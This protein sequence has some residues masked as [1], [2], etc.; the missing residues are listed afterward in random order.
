MLGQC[1]LSSSCSTGVMPCEASVDT[2]NS[3]RRTR[4]DFGPTTHKFGCR[5]TRPIRRAG[6]RRVGIST[7]RRTLRNS[8]ESPQRPSPEVTCPHEAPLNPVVEQSLCLLEIR[9]IETLSEPGINRLKQIHVVRAPK[10][11]A[12]PL[13]PAATKPRIWLSSGSCSRHCKTTN[14]RCW[15]TKRPV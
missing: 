13:Y 10:S 2:R 7:D 3:Q 11:Q 15:R 12:H 5:E 4:G 8:L 6:R 1:S 9:N 14:V